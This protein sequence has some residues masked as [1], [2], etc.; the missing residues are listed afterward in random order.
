LR[1]L[2]AG[3]QTTRGRLGGDLT[4]SVGKRERFILQ[5]MRRWKP[6]KTR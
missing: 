2:K 4:L 6:T 5:R 1:I 3:G